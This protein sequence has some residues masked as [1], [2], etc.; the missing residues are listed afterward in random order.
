MPDEIKLLST[1]SNYLK[2]I[3]I[4]ESPH[5]H[6][7]TSQAL[8]LFTKHI[9]SSIKKPSKLSV[10]QLSLNWA[11]NFLVYL[12]EH[13]S[14]ETEHLYTRAILDFYQYTVE[15]Y[16]LPLETEELRTFFSQ[17]RRHKTHAI[18][19][20]PVKII[21]HT[22]KYV[23]N[24]PSPAPDKYRT[25]LQHLRDKAF[26]LLIVQTGLRLSEICNLRRYQINLDKKTIIFG[27]DFSLAIPQHTHSA[28]KAYLLSR[29]KLDQQQLVHSPEHLPLF[30]RHDKRASN[31]I[32]PIS[33]WTGA[34]IIDGWFEQA[35]STEQ[36]QKIQES[37]QKITAQ[38][39]RH[40]FVLTKLEETQGN[41]DKVQILA[42][43]DD[44]L[45]TKQY[46]EILS[47]KEDLG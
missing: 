34:N 41:I 17:N 30:A 16:Q 33:R 9:A 29:N 20:I 14:I 2:Y 4:H 19:P 23:K 37:D 13:R 32:L 42:R 21:E 11:K 45:T 22:L 5:I 25:H 27:E 26:I 47:K 7:S 3:E 8:S 35:L 18:P 24:A 12:Q 44:I 40:Y 43:H 1:I 31:R 28:L 15:H 10:D 46:L 6:Q 38:T 36:Y 39:L